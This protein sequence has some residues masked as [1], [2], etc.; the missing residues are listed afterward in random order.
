MVKLVWINE[1]FT[2]DDQHTLGHFSTHASA[3]RFARH[4]ASKLGVTGDLSRRYLGDGIT[5]LDT[6]NHET[7]LWIIDPS[8]A[9]LRVG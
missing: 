9:R 3:A 6:G 8:G 5:S 1:L 4:R 7:H 2:G